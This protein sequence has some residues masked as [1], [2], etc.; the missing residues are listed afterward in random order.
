MPAQAKPICFCATT[1]P[2]KSRTFY[3][4]L[5]GFH[6]ISDSTVALVFD[7]HGTMLRV[8][9]VEKLTPQPFTVLG[10]DVKDIRATVKELSEK[11]V[12][13]KRYKRLPQ[14]ELGIWTTPDKDRVAW[15]KDPDGNILSLTQFK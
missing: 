3:R 2:E 9:K 10:W 4:D 6:L 5:L 7:M 12:E 13:F 14:D 8:Q 15:F 11:G 1:Q